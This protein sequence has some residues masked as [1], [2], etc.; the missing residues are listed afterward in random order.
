M[1][2]CKPARRSKVARSTVAS[3]P[4]PLPSCHVCAYALLRSSPAH[5]AM[6]LAR[7][8]PYFANGTHNTMVGMGGRRR[9]ACA[10]LE[11]AARSAACVACAV[12][13]EWGASR[14]S[15]HRRRGSAPDVALEVRVPR[16]PR[17]LRA[18]THTPKRAGVPSGRPGCRST[19]VP[20]SAQGG[21]NS[22]SAFARRCW[23]HRT[24]SGTCKRCKD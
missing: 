7:M 19:G 2:S 4:L 6:G 5:S 23:I 14:A 21:A 11:G 1:S 9:G 12:T 8:W 3:C 15:P 17:N 10:A 16:Q 13:K 22:Q 24:A 18:A 20:R